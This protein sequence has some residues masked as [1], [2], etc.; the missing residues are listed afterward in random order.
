MKST[1]ASQTAPSSSNSRQYTRTMTHYMPSYKAIMT[2]NG[3][4]TCL[5]LAFNIVCSPFVIMGILLNKITH[6]HQLD[7]RNR[8]PAAKEPII[9]PM[10]LTKRTSLPPH[11]PTSNHTTRQSQQATTRTDQKLC[12]QKSL[13]TRLTKPRHCVMQLRPLRTTRETA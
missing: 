6:N 8:P 11:T 10:V 9:P 4:K 5:S 3:Q 2:A 12:R 13:R 1:L 7:Y